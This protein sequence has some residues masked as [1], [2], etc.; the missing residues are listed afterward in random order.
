MKRLAAALAVL[1]LVATSLMSIRQAHAEEIVVVQVAPFTGNLAPTGRDIHKGAKLYF[2]AVNARGGINGHRIR[3][4]SYDDGYKT[5]LTVQRVQEAIARDRPI[6]ILGLVGTG[7]VEAL[8][9]R[10]ILRGIPV[11]GVRTGASSVRADPQIF[12]LRASYAD[13][14]G[15]IIDHLATL[16]YNRIAVLYQGDG[17]GEEGLAGVNAAMRRHKLQL[18]AAAA[19]E[20]NTVKVEAAVA[21]IRKAAPQAVVMI[22]NTAASAEFVKRMR[23]AGDNCALYAVS[24]TDLHQVM[25]RIGEKTARGLAVAQVMP[26]PARGSV[27]LVKELG[28]LVAQSGDPEARVTFT[29]VEGYLM[30]KTLVEGLRRAGKAPTR[31]SLH[32][33]LSGVQDWDAGGLTVSFTGGALEGV[34]HVELSMLGKGGLYQ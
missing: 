21:A 20:K 6:A 7:N 11:V 8:V 4:V 15:K 2:D 23:E 9:K 31:L 10:D 12:H 24:V 14:T 30:A 26:N 28:Q 22:S 27:P 33:A 25:E 18:V 13:E 16:S 34:R 29:S 17:F 32:R 19:Y 3:F 5:D 1:A